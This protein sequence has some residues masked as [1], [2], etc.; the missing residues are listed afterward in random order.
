MINR[1]WSY[2]PP[3]AEDEI[4]HR[5]GQFDTAVARIEDDV[6]EVFATMAAAVDGPTFLRPM[7]ATTT[8][9]TLR[10]PALGGTA[11]DPIL[12]PTTRRC[13][14]STRSRAALRAIDERSLAVERAL[15]PDDDEPVETPRRGSRPL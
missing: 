4:D 15:R 5:I 11:G 9:M 10:P 8:A 2:D 13:P 1:L 6:V 3:L 12:T 7:T 14:N